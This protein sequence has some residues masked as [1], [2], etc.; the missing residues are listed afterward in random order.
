VM[1]RAIFTAAPA[2][3]LIWV[4]ANTRSGND[5]LATILARVLDPVGH[6]IG[7]D[8]AVMLAY[9]IAIP[10]N[11]IVVPTLM[12]VYSKGSMMMEEGGY[13]AMRALLVDGNGWT[14]LTA[15]S[16]MLFSLLHNPCGTTILTI[17]KETG[18]VRWTLVGALMPLA[19]AFGVCFAVAGIARL[20]G[21]AG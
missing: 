11:E 6:A 8:G 12:M 4:L 2:G 16:L 20:L 3:A 1:Y 9:I 14:M 10:A 15:V 19:I 17:W 13:E 7:L 5:S 21:A 18:S